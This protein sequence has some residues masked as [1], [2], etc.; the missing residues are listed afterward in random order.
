MRL[1]H[2]AVRAHEPRLQFGG[3]VTDIAALEPAPRVVEPL[4]ARPPGRPRARETQLQFLTIAVAH[5]DG[6]R[7]VPQ[8]E[9]EPIGRAGVADRGRAR[10]ASSPR[11]AIDPRAEVIRAIDDELRGVRRRRRAHVRHE[12]RDREIHFVADG[13]N[14]RHGAGR[15]RAGERLVVERPEILGRS[16]AAADDH[17]VDVGH[18]G[19]A[20]SAR[21]RSCAAP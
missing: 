20:P 21:T 3:D 10:G 11:G 6:N 13:R 18:A 5:H 8:P 14:H 1:A 9:R 19:I 16:A 12:I 4:A 15:N 7:P 17:D 2:A